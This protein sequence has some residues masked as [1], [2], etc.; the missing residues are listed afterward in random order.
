MG[1][2][3]RFASVLPGTASGLNGADRDPLAKALRDV[4]DG[5][6]SL[7]E[8][9]RERRLISAND[10]DAF[11]RGRERVEKSGLLR[12]MQET[13]VAINELASRTVVDSHAFL[14][15]DPTLG[16]FIFVEG[17][18][19]FTL[20]L[21]LRGAS[22]YLVFAERKWRDTA[23]NDFVRWAYRMVEVE[24]MSITVKLIH[25]VQDDQVSADEVRHWFFY[26]I[27]GFD[28]AYAPNFRRRA[29]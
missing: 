5:S 7:A 6:A 29:S 20:R 17:S 13:C 15:P 28:R 3:G 19:E 9:L 4:R 24:P 21:E 14:A 27:S 25:E 16:C 18:S 23:A 2:L 22:P 1:I 10:G 12:M 26:L 8:F 11:E